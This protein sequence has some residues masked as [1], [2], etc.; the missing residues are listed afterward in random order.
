MRVDE[1][2]PKFSRIT[3]SLSLINHSWA[4]LLSPASAYP[5]SPSALYLIHLLTY[6]LTFLAMAIV[7]DM[8]L[9]V[10][11]FDPSKHLKVRHSLPPSVP[12]SCR[13]L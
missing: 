7:L 11:E 10:A 4:F 12:P 13:P 1:G 9:T 3:P 8:W 6:P 5:A 2:A